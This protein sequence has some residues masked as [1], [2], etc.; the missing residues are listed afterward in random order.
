[1]QASK[2]RP[3]HAIGGGL[4]AYYV[5]RR[6]RGAELFAAAQTIV[7]LGEMLPDQIGAQVFSRVQ[8]DCDAAR[9]EIAAIDMIVCRAIE[10]IAVPL[11]PFARETHGKPIVD[12]GKVDH[13]F[14]TL[15][16]V[17]A[18][19]GRCHR[20]ELIGRLGRCDVHHARRR[21]AAVERTL[22]AA[23]HLDLGDVEE[24]LFEE[25]VANE[26]LIVEGDRD[27]R[28]GGDG[29]GLRADAA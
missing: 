20:F 9:P 27:R 28:I 6:I 22:G 25:M 8:T 14:E 3:S 19:F 7:V 10:G 26:R 17:I 1:M 18:D 16:A 23:Q 4:A 29:N 12:D 24:F 21:I 2:R 13:A 11:G 5:R 15:L